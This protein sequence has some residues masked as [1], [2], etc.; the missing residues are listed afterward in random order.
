MKEFDLKTCIDKGPKDMKSGINE[1][2]HMNYAKYC[3]ERARR[4]FQVCQISI[5]LSNR[6]LVPF[7]NFQHMQEQIRGEMLN[8]LF[9]KKCG[10]TALAIMNM[11]PMPMH[12][13][14]DFDSTKSMTKE[15]DDFMEDVYDGK[16]SDEKPSSSKNDTKT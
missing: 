15:I 9:G 6:Y 16:I 13:L 4:E 3:M 10:F 2:S 8:R 12:Q 11:L 7:C 1:I 14:K 5:N